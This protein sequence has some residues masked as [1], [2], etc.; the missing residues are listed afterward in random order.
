MTSPTEAA[1]PPPDILKDR[2]IVVHGG[3]TIILNRPV[4][5]TDL[6]GA[7]VTKVPTEETEYEKGLYPRESHFRVM[8]DV[9]IG[10]VDEIVDD[11]REKLVRCFNTMACQND[12]GSWG[13]IPQLGEASLHKQQEVLDKIHPR[14]SHGVTPLGCMKIDPKVFIERQ[15]RRDKMDGIKSTT[16]AQD[17]DVLMRL[18]A[19][20]QGR[21]CGGH[22]T[23]PPT[24]D[25]GSVQQLINALTLLQCDNKKRTE[26]PVRMEC[27]DAEVKPEAPVESNEHR[28][29]AA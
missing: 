25:Y 21:R 29:A 1:P 17:R 26:G 28:P 3:S 13:V 15:K 2:M 24:D 19:L 5:F 4:E 16:H 9:A 10:T 22:G 11:Y 7:W 27:T 6:A 23:S 8:L 20:W 18:V 12:D 14:G